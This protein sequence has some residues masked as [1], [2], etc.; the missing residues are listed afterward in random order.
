MSIKRMNVV[1]VGAG[2]HGKVIVSLLQELGYNIV[3]VLDDD[4]AKWGSV[5]LS[6]PVDGPVEKLQKLPCSEAILAIGSNRTRLCLAEKFP[7]TTWLSAVHTHSWVHPSVA[8]GEGTVIFA[9]S[10]VQPDTVI[11]KH[12][13]I[14]TGVTVDHDCQ[15]RDGVHLAPGC[16]LAGG[17]TVGKGAF[18]G[19][20]VS[21]IP[22]CSIGKGTIVGA[23]A[24]IVSDLPDNIVAVGVPAKPVRSL[25]QGK[26]E[27]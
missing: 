16:H 12:C 20:G 15:I 6:I 5:I 24:S 19:V 11:G 21:V 9:G 17:V 4:I 22:G 13:I 25:L 8:I 27:G 3:V 1:I 23:G 10:I 18:L 14:N 7:D 2:G 26:K